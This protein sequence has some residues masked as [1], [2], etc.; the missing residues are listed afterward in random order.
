MAAR[1]RSLLATLAVALG[2]AVPAAAF[3]QAPPDTPNLDELMRQGMPGRPQHS[4]SSGA[5][6]VPVPADSPLITAFRRLDTAKTYRVVMEMSTTDPRA[7][8]A[9]QQMG[10]MDLYD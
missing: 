1:I 6:G 7:Q 10:G 3:G 4:A 9:M 8:Q 2:V 5:P